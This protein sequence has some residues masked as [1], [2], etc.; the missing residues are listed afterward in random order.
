MLPIIAAMD[1]RN[2]YYTHLPRAG[3]L[4][5]RP[6]PFVR[7]KWGNGWLWFAASCS[8][9][10]TSNN[11]EG[12]TA[13]LQLL[14]N[15]P[16]KIGGTPETRV[17]TFKDMS[18][19]DDIYKGV[20]NHLSYPPGTFTDAQRE[21]AEEAEIA[22]LPWT[23]SKEK[24]ADLHEGGVSQPGS[25]VEIS[26]DILGG[27][28]LHITGAEGKL[29]QSLRPSHG[30]II[31]L[32]PGKDNAELLSLGTRPN[33]L[34]LGIFLPIPFLLKNSVIL[35][36]NIRLG[37]NFLEQVEKVLLHLRVVGEGRNRGGRLSQLLLLVNTH[38]PPFILL[39]ALIRHLPSP[40]L[41]IPT[42]AP[43]TFHPVI[44][45]DGLW[46]YVLQQVFVDP[47][48]DLSQ[49]AH[50]LQALSASHIPRH[51]MMVPFLLKLTTI[52]IELVKE[53]TV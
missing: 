31:P 32:L 46:V 4:R 37:E 13:T 30:S 39:T 43:S 35:R 21:L 10:T 52:I 34:Q 14:Y 45:V 29:V 9:S 47:V 41:T 26:S 53:E 28:T 24:L 16:F 1:L 8:L 19:L 25:Y 36:E 6:L 48:G 17:L 5:L 33:Y 42:S 38:P 7:S 11:L 12:Y 40:C 27:Q 50:S 49:K 22:N 15:M 2:I 23:I 51:W 44:A 20:P 18:A 3:Y